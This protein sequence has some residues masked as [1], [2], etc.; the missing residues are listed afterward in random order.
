MNHQIIDKIKVFTHSSICL[1]SERVIYIDP[2]QIRQELHNADLILITHDHYDH[3]SPEDIDR[4]LKL[5]K[6]TML[7]VPET[8]IKQAAQINLPKERIISVMPEQQIEVCGIPIETVSAYNAIKPF[9]PKQKKWV[10][11]IVTLEQTR[12]YIAGDTDMTPENQKV[13]CDIAMVPIGGTYT[14]NAK[15]AAY[16]VNCIKPQ[17]AIPTHFGAI[18]GKP[19]DALAFQ[20]EV[21][22]DIQV[23]DKLFAK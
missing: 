4:V 16:L 13:S 21:H 14:M 22:S 1:E 11:Y 8:M 6:E 20:K 17:A 9:H 18:V 7:V 5:N 19:E 10:G 12:I 15:K 2:Y 3:F 23:I